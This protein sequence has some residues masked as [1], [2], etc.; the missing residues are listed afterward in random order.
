MKMGLNKEKMME[1]MKTQCGGNYTRF[2][3]ELGLDA[4]H[5]YRFLNT[6]V[7]GGKTMIF[8]LMNFCEKK[9]L[10]YRDFFDL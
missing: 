6:G 7:G 2:G 3:R 1:L 5:I 8:S 4:A 10:D 9:N